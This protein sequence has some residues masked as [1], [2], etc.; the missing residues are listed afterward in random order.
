M[1]HINF[2]DAP[3]F[4]TH[5][6]PRPLTGFV[7]SETWDSPYLGPLFTL[8][9]AIPVRRGEADMNAIRRGVAA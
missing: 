6:C 7:K 5:L 2:L 1:N 3:I 4:Y 9:G 8:W